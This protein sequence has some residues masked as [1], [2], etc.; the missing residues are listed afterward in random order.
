MIWIH[1]P[2][3]YLVPAQHENSNNSKYKIT[4]LIIHSMCLMLELSRTLFSIFYGP[5]VRSF[6]FKFFF[7]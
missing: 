7:C 3:F 6:L 4:K 2:E 1:F 5:M